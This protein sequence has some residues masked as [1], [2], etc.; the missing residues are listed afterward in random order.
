MAP[1]CGG[2]MVEL[3]GCGPYIPNA[4]ALKKSLNVR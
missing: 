4:S 3:D 2:A 1:S